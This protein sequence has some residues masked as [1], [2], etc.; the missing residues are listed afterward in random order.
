MPHTDPPLLDL[1]FTYDQWKEEYDA[2]HERLLELCRYMKWNPTNYD[3]HD[4]DAHHRMVRDKFIPFMTDWRQHLARERQMIYPVAESVICGGRMGPIAVLE[5]DVKIADQYFEGYF[6]AIR[7]GAPAEDALDRLLQVLI[8]V[9][10][11]F[12]IEDETILP[13]TE[14]LMNHERE[15]GTGGLISD[16]RTDRQIAMRE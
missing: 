7:D 15:N 12:R 16:S 2:L 8:I 13:V 3:Y 6:E 5:Q 9:A 10:E 14:R 4:W 11:H 1:Y